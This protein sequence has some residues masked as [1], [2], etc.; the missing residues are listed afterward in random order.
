MKPRE[1]AQVCSFG[2]WSAD[3]THFLAAEVLNTDIFDKLATDFDSFFIGFGLWN[4]HSVLKLEHSSNVELLRTFHQEILFFVFILRQVTRSVRFLA[5]DIIFIYDPH[6]SA[7]FHACWQRF[8][9][10]VHVSDDEVTIVVHD[11]DFLTDNVTASVEAVR[12]NFPTSILRLRVYVELEL[13]FDAFT[14]GCRRGEAVTVDAV[15]VR[16]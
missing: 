8:S 5:P 14:V 10:V 13:G 2:S 4:H 16:H 1:T 12:L 7:L 11:A 3:F 9:A 15:S 6:V